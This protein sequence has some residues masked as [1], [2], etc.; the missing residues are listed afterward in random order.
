MSSSVLQVA[1]DM[2]RSIEKLSEAM[3]IPNN[4]P[5]TQFQIFPQQ[6]YFSTY[7][8]YHYNTNKLNQGSLSQQTASSSSPIPKPNSNTLDDR[9]TAI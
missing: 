3:L 1:Q 6:T 8:H 5:Y 9:K 7:Q 2:T 4:R